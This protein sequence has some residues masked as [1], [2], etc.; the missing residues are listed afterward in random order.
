MHLAMT[1][2]I[3][4]TTAM[5]FNVAVHDIW[6]VDDGD[7]VDSDYDADYD[8]SD[9]DIDIVLEDGNTDS[10]EADD[11]DYDDLK[12]PKKNAFKLQALNHALPKNLQECYD[13]YFESGFKI[14]P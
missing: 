12:K 3:I 10:V 13:R 2:T 6:A 14:N 1:L 8:D 11:E 4:I 5:S 9:S 7:A